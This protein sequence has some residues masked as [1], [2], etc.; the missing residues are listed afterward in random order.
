MKFVCKIYTC[1]KYLTISMYY[2]LRL[3]SNFIDKINMIIMYVLIIV[4]LNHRNKCIGTF[5]LHLEL[6]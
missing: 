6:I 2:M 4:H 3:V 1:T 5:R